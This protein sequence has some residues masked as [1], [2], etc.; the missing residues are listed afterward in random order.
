MGRESGGPGEGGSWGWR[1]EGGGQGGSGWRA[2]QAR[3]GEDVTRRRFCGAAGLVL[4][5]DGP[6]WP[7]LLGSLP[8]S[9][10]SGPSAFLSGVL[11]AVGQDTSFPVFTVRPG[12]RIG[13]TSPVSDDSQ[14]SV[15]WIEALI[16][17]LV[18]T[19]IKACR[20][21]VNCSRPRR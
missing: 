12:L 3:L 21:I 16:I 18:F 1:R 13:F 20:G 10:L 6:A 8:A 17:I 7:G 15:G 19:E 2:A 4:G 14:P 5:G 9:R 11:A